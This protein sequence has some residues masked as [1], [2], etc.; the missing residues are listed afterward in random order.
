[1]RVP[2]CFML[3]GIVAKYSFVI[4]YILIEYIFFSF[5]F[6]PDGASLLCQQLQR[7]K[8]ENAA[9]VSL[10]Y[11]YP[12]IVPTPLLT[13]SQ[14][15][16]T[17]LRCRVVLIRIPAQQNSIRRPWR[18]APLLAMPGKL[19]GNIIKSVEQRCFSFLCF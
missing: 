17:W 2:D 12:S 7:S 10:P 13:N 8:Q 6:S 16:R 11:G 5:V 3:V 15:F 18:I 1:M 4:G 14:D 19:K 9:P